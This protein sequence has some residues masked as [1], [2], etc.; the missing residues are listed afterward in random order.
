MITSILIA[1]SAG[2][3]LVIQSIA[4]TRCRALRC[5]REKPDVEMTRPNKANRPTIEV[6]HNYEDEL[7]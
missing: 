4:L 7:L 5:V 6:V 3:T 2:L 1:I